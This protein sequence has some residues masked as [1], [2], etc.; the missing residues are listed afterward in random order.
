MLLLGLIPWFLKG[1]DR[2]PPRLV[3]NQVVCPWNTVPET[4]GLLDKQDIVR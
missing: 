4:H 3:N 1:R 2:S